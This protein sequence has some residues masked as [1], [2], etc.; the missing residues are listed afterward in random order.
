MSEP[1]AVD[2]QLVFH[3]GN[4]DETEIAAITAVLTS[5]VQQQAAADAAPRPTEAPSAWQR[6]QRS[7]RA[8]LTPVPGTWR[9]FGV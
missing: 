1:D 6:S 5:V 3:T 4:L 8:T 9:T 2:P 7:M